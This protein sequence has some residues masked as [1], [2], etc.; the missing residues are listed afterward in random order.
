MSLNLL[1]TFHPVKKEFEKCQR[2][3]GM[4][5][6]MK[7]LQLAL[8]FVPTQL[9]FQTFKML[10]CKYSLQTLKDLSKFAL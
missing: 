9:G 2:G 4:V 5:K 8:K 7:C 3:S 10:F 1:T 6:L